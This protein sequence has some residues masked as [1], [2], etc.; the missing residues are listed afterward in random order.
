M[1]AYTAHTAHG[2]C[3]PVVN[4]AQG[5]TCT[6]TGQFRGLVPVVSHSLLPF[7]K[8]DDEMRQTCKSAGKF[9]GL[10]PVLTPV[11]TACLEAR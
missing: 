5:Q 2:A 9:R 4:L 3:T 7:S 10:M 8:P 1:A 11:F 6:S